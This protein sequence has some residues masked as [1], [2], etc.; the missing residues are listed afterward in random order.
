MG[1]V[2]CQVDDVRRREDLEFTYYAI[3]SVWS[4]P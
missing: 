3:G 2:F 4:S 1:I